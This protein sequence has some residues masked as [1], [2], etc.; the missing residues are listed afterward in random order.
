MAGKAEQ[1]IGMPTLPP[2]MFGGVNPMQQTFRPFNPASAA[3][4]GSVTTG[5]SNYGAFNP[6]PGLTPVTSPV[7]APLDQ[8]SIWDGP[9][10]SSPAAT[11]S[12][13]FTD[14]MF[15]LPAGI[16]GIEK[17]NTSDGPSGGK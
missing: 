3:Q 10:S 9:D 12:N 1:L 14:P 15:G 11:S 8:R 4:L 7:A 2:E 6:S 5:K 13:G 16:G 17:G